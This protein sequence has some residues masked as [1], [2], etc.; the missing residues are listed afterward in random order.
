MNYEQEAEALLAKLL[1][2]DH[3]HQKDMV[4]KKLEEAFDSGY[5]KSAKEDYDS[6][7]E[8]YEDGEQRGRRLRE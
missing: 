3:I 5:K 1:G 7:N 4:Y 6:Y 2:E 8:G